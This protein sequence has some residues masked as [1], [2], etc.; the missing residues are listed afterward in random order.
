MGL[1]FI[2][3]EEVRALSFSKLF[4]VGYVHISLSDY[5]SHF[6]MI[7]IFICCSLITRKKIIN[8]DLV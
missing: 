4:I 5:S 3:S 7:F 6:D 2:L 1:N 8:L